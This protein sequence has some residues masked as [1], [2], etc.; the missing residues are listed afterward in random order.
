MVKYTKN[1][2]L[3]LD[4]HHQWI[5]KEKYID[6]NDPILEKV[7]ETWQGKRPLMHLSTSREDV[8][9]GHN[10]NKMPDIKRLLK[11][12]F[13]KSKLRSHSD[14]MWNKAVN[15]YAAQFLKYADLELECK[16]KN[17]GATHFIQTLK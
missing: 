16:A 3:V 17:L 12:G 10:K 9:V 15:K 14:Y 1:I 2:A 8:L 13:N 5:N 11:K 7:W 4:L 6:I